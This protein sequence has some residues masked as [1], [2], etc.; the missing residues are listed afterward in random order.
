MPSKQTFPPAR[1]ALVILIAGVVLLTFA[2]VMLVLAFAVG[3]GRVT[4]EAYQQCYGF[5]AATTTLSAPNVFV[6]RFVLSEEDFAK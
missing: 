3:N 5:R 6:M 1:R 2:G 4:A